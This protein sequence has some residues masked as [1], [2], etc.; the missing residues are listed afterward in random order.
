LSNT[1]ITGGG[2]LGVGTRAPGYTA[3]IIGSTTAATGVTGTAILTVSNDDNTTS[4]G[5]NVLRLNSRFGATAC[6]AATTC[7]RFAE[8][9]RGV[10]SGAQT[11][12]TGIG[13]IRIVSGG[14]SVSYTTTAA[15]FGE[16]QIINGGGTTGDVVSVGSGGIYHKAVAGEPIV[17]VISVGAGFVG[18]AGIETLADANIVGF[19]GVIPTTVSNENGNITAGD[20][21]SVLTTSGVGSKLSSSGYALGIA[22]ANYTSAT[23]GTIDVLVSPKWVDSSA[24]NNS[25]STYSLLSGNS[26]FFNRSSTT[27]LITLLNATDTVAL[28]GYLYVPT[29]FAS[30]TNAT[31]TNAV[32]FN[33]TTG[34]ISDSSRSDC[35]VC[36][37]QVNSVRSR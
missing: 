35:C 6:V 36:S 26:G 37:Y 25:T 28:G 8:F 10:A 16:Y 27:A 7:P 17:G 29:I 32:N 31:T 5:N 30:T 14:G 11:G 12:G 1:V 23:P 21:I 13:S 18:N 2:K 24:I 3:S 20:T 33:G 9:F 34:K 22:L 15:D 4:S 19:T